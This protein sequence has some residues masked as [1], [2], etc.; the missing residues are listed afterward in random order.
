MTGFYSIYHL[1]SFFFIY[2]LRVCKAIHCKFEFEELRQL[3]EDY[4]VVISY[5]FPL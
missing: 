3:T 5:F 4:S 2:N 1:V